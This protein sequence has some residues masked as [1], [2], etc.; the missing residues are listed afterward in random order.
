MEFYA[1]FS[2]EAFVVA[3]RLLLN[4]F[5]A[6]EVVQE[7]ILK[8]LINEKLLL[9][10]CQAMS[11]YIRRMTVNASTDILRKRGK[12]LTEDLHENIDIA[13][14]YDFDEITMREQRLALLHKAIVELP[15]GYRTIVTLHIVE[16]LDYEEIADILHLTPSTIRSQMA[17]AKKKIIE[18][19]DKRQYEKE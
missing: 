16:E 6:E 11:K 1:R 3:Y 5:E 2:H 9:D 15:S 13:D 4:T 17:R 18:W 8:I 7:V 14:E 19:F 12:I 10:E